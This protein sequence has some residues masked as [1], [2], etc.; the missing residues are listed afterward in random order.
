[1]ADAAGSVNLPQLAA[2]VRLRRERE[3]RAVEELAALRRRKVEAEQAREAA[4]RRVETEETARQT[5]EQRVYRVLRQTAPLSPAGLEHHCETIRNLSRHVAE[6]SKHRQTTT[7]ALHEAD[8][9]VER[10]RIRLVA[11]VRDRRK[12]SEIEARVQDTSHR[13]MQMVTERESEDDI[14]LRYGRLP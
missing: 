4:E 10:G 9:A 14:D 5:G 8:E 6:A 12:W 11:K 13:H 7:A 2:L 3:R 1:M